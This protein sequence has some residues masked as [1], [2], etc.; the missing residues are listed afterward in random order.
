VSTYRVCNHFN[1][2]RNFKWITA[3]P[4]RPIVIY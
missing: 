2:G 3:N 1:T 4:T